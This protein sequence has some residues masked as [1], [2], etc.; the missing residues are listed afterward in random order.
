MTRKPDG[1]AAIT[2]AVLAIQGALVAALLLYEDIYLIRLVSFLDGTWSLWV[3][4]AV[5]LVELFTLLPGG[6]MVLARKRAGR[7][8]IVVGC[9]V[10]LALGIAVLGS[11]M[12]VT[13][14]GLGL[15]TRQ[16]SPESPLILLVALIPAVLTL[17]LVLLPYTTDWLAW[18]DPSSFL[19]RT[20]YYGPP[21]GYGP[22]PTASQQP[23]GQQSPG[24]QSHGQQSGYFPPAS[25]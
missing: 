20:P 11:G 12:P 6:I 25:S 16:S 4:L 24:Q 8:L 2:A 1:R 19:S 18:R 17:V 5:C 23:Y 15:D 13:V 7:W 3:L 14:R 10:H 22:Q 21:S 9:L